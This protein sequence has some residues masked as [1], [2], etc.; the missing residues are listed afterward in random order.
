MVGMV[1]YFVT[2]VTS[3]PMGTMVTVVTKGTN[4]LMVKGKK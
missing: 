2:I 3:I 4:I 1:T